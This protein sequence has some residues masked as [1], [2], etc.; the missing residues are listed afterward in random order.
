[1]PLPPIAFFPDDLRMTTWLLIEASLQRILSLMLP[2]YIASVPALLILSGRVV[3]NTLII[4]GVLRGP[5]LDR[6]VKGRMTAQ[7]PLDDGSFPERPSKKKVV[8]LFL[9]ARSNQCVLGCQWLQ[10]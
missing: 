3:Q 8:L 9:G 7:I 10:V 5:S 4:Q 2:I 1:M 6:V